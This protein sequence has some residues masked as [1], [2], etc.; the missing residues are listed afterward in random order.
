MSVEKGAIVRTPKKFNVFSGTK[1]VGTICPT[2]IT[3][4]IV[5][6]VK[7]L[8]KSYFSDQVSQRSQI[9]GVALCTSKGKVHWLGQSVSQWQGHL[10]SRL[11]QLKTDMKNIYFGSDLKPEAVPG[12]NFQCHYKCPWAKLFEQPPP[13]KLEFL[14]GNKPNLKR[15]EHWCCS[16]LFY[17][18]REPLLSATH[19]YSCNWH[20]NGSQY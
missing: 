19:G 5:M 6:I 3:W 16:G 8:V 14:L 18:H 4:K 11:V 9:S 7:M 15:G 17:S 13:L 12:K 1:I 10:L 20:R 2:F